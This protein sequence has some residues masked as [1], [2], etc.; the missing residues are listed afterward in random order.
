M[1]ES[2]AATDR[3][4]HSSPRIP[5]AGVAGTALAMAQRPFSNGVTAVRRG[6]LLARQASQHSPD[7]LES[8]RNCK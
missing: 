4:G 7:H 8:E 1:S 2:F 6:H 5:L 3:Q